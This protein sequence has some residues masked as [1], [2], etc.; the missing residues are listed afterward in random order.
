MPMP[1]EIVESVKESQWMKDGVE[2]TTY[3]VTLVDGV[4]QREVPFYVPRG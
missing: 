4:G 2:A 3:W 1:S